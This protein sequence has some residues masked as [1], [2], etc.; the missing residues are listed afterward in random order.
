MVK[1][2][3]GSKT[4]THNRKGFYHQKM[5]Y[6]GHSMKTEMNGNLQML[7]ADRSENG[8]DQEKEK[9]ENSGLRNEAISGRTSDMGRT[10]LNMKMKNGMKMIGRIRT[11]E[12]EKV[13]GR[14]ER[15]ARVTKERTKTPT[16][17]GSRENPRKEKENQ[18]TRTS[19]KM[20]MDP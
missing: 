20:P 7:P 18:K 10:P 15:K 12:K 11:L 4:K 9:E 8:K 19:R 1:K 14:K 5:T 17:A 6:S 3:T 2:V 16:R 13:V